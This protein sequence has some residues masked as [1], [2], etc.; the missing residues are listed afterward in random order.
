MT[1]PILQAVGKT[2]PNQTDL[3]PLKNM[4]NT[5]KNARNPQAM[6]MN[7]AQQNPNV[8]Q[9]MDFINQ[10]GGD[11]KTAFYKMAEQKGVDP[12]SILS[13]LR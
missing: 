7:M 9:A 6:L 3:G 11:P 10:F 8:K 4:M 5:V 13:Q 1:N 2:S 12:E